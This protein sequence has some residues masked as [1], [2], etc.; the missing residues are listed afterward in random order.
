MFRRKKSEVAVPKIP[1]VPETGGGSVAKP[2]AKPP[3]RQVTPLPV[4]NPIPARP[5]TASTSRLSGIPGMDRRRPDMDTYTGAES[6]TLVVGRDI[7]LNGHDISCDRLVV[8]G[9]VEAEK[10]ESRII[11]ISKDGHLKG[12]AVIEN[13]EISGWF[14]GSLEVS[15]RLVI[16]AGGRVIG[17]IRYGQLEIEAGGEI[18]GDV[19]LISPS[20]GETEEPLPLER[21]TAVERKSRERQ[22]ARNAPGA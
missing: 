3:A 10:V 1:I 20:E 18:S 7:C 16:H 14:E 13:A 8:E 19:K 2:M 6:K 17:R 21:M 9:S 4:A 12:A 5:F 11:E 22:G 15:K